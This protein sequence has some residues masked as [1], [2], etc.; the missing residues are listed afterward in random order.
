MSLDRLD[1]LATG[2]KQ[3]PSTLKRALNEVVQDN[4]YVL[5]LDNQHQLEEGLD[6]NNRDITPEYTDF[7]IDKKQEA[8]QPYDRAASW[9]RCAVRK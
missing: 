5:E 2:L 6:S 7:T 4:A 1:A 3:L 8:G 9:P